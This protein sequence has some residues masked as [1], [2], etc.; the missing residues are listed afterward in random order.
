MGT[1]SF[2][3]SLVRTV[4]P[5]LFRISFWARAVEET[6]GKFFSTDALLVRIELTFSS[7]NI[8]TLITTIRNTCRRFFKEN[9]FFGLVE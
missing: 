4:A 6:C 5:S 7:L 1:V 9:Y 2:A 3:A 8:P